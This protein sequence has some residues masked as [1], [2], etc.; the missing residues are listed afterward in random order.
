MRNILSPHGRTRRTN[1]LLGL[2]AINL[3]GIAVRGQTTGSTPAEASV[4]FIVT[5]IMM[6][7]LYCLMTRR[8]H[9]ADRTSIQAILTLCCAVI[10]A[11]FAGVSGTL[12]VRSDLPATI[13]LFASLA[14]AASSIS[15]MVMRPTRGPNRYGDDPRRRSEDSE[16]VIA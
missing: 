11:F 6:W 15:M 7:P 5:A 12:A 13:S 4:G 9:D 3:V 16:G 8:L 10:A 1:Y 2:V 14:L